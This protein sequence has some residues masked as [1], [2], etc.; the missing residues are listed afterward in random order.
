MPVPP[1][2]IVVAKGYSSMAFFVAVLRTPIAAGEE[3]KDGSFYFRIGA[4][5]TPNIRDAAGGAHR[6]GG[7][8]YGNDLMADWRN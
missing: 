5:S 6:F 7:Q 4:A 3:K 8:T 1:P 2:S